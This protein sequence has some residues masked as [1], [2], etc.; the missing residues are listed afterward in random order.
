MDLRVSASVLVM[1]DETG[2]DANTIRMMYKRSGDRSC[3]YILYHTIYFRLSS[4][5]RLLLI[6]YM[7]ANA[8]DSLKRKKIS[9]GLNG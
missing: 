7:N 1:D 6:A 9:L 5:G 4:V 3:R 8:L 2:R